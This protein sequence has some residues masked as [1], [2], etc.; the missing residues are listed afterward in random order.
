MSTT[1]PNDLPDSGAD[2]DAVPIDRNRAA[3]ASS[4]LRLLPREG[5]GQL[6]LPYEYDVAPGVP[7]L[8]PAQPGLH[9]VARE[10]SD[11]NDGLLD[12]Y[13]WVPRLARGIA[14]VAVGARPPGQLTRHVARDELAR[15]AR[16]GQQVA[17]HPSSRMQRGVTRLRAV[18]GVRV[19]H[20]A[21]GILEASAVL[22]GGERAHAIAMRLEAVNGR[23]LATVVQ[24][25]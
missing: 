2:D 5:R 10:E 21:P 4:R 6:S 13:I 7:A 24:L 15:L 16:R 19:C 23:W 11:E 20:V 12:P 9:I 14:E 17:R 25:G 3:A 22:I 1:I 8:P 18:R